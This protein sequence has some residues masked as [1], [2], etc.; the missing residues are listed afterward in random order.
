[1]KRTR[2]RS[3]TALLLAL[4][5]TLTF[6][7]FGGR[8]ALAADVPSS[9]AQAEIDEA[10]AKG[11]ITSPADGNYLGNIS[12]VLFCIHIVNMVETALGTSVTVT[13]ANPFNDVENEYVT[14]AYQLGIVN[15]KSATIFDPSAFITRQE[16]AAMMMRSARALDLAAGKTYAAISGTESLS[17]ADQ[18]EISSWAL[19]DVRAANGLGI[20][21]GVGDN[22][23]NPLGNT[24]VQE[25]ILLVN[26]LYDGFMDA[27]TAGTGTG[28]VNAAPEALDNPVE[29]SSLE[30]TELVIEAD[31][32]ASDDDGDILTVIA[33]NGQT[34]PHS[35]PYGTAELTSD[36]K[37]SY[38]S[39]DISAGI[40]DDFVVTVSDGTDP[41]FVNVRVNL[42]VKLV[43]VL[44]PSLGSVSVTGSPVVVGSL[45]AGMITYL[46]GVPSTSPTLTYQWLSAASS[47]GTYSAI[48]GATSSSYALTSSAVGKYFKLQV[49]A[50]GSA[51]GTAES[52][53]VG[54]VVYHFAGGNG[55][56][57]QPY[58]IETAAHLQLLND[59]PTEGLWFALNNDI[60]MPSDT[61]ITA[62][63]QGKLYG[64][65]H[66]VTLDIG[67]C[68]GNYVG[69]FS[70]TGESALVYGVL[71]DGSIDTPY[72]VAGGISGRNDGTINQ[73][74]SSVSVSA[75]SYAGGITGLNV[76]TV[77]LC[78]SEA[79]LFTE[80]GY[81]GGLVGKNN[82]NISRSSVH[83]AAGVT[84][85]EECA[86]GLAGYNSTTGQILNCYAQASVAGGTYAGGLV[87]SNAGSVQKC[88]STGAVSGSSGLGGLIGSN[89]G[90]V[91][92]S[93]YDKNTSGR[94]DTGKG[95]PMTT[96]EMKTKTT[97][98]GWEFTNIW[99]YTSGEYLFL[100]YDPSG[101]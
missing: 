76:G 38:V 25:S 86:G 89:G 53:A 20:M 39:E 72:S 26:R 93:Y 69:L 5:I 1:M 44:T 29:F 78:S 32:L 7:G 17:F 63:F 80:E 95:V 58:V 79:E 100:K 90:S 57:S 101:S 66:T 62:T 37:I 47:D 22:R 9:W 30:Q 21:K 67:T 75:K 68:P 74:F 27:P 97:F 14:K 85:S 70:Q 56:N 10:R 60:T 18:D 45:R 15:G 59:I 87:G 48:F 52:S 73:C 64:Y 96:T 31:E 46:G 42:K 88:Y 12:R 36:G 40:P 50:S 71:V 92:E 49:T 82:N 13:A 35:T 16:I 83:S 99:G 3:F 55:S 65:G 98:S 81:A 54:P 41:V 19:S 77:F 24:T 6:F 94:S 34:A 28:T 51:G 84:T 43:L 8:S 11:L 2:L 23:I 4:A 61:Y 33:I 91:Q